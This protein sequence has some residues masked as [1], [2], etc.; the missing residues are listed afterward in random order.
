LIKDNNVH[1][2]AEVLSRI[3]KFSSRWIGNY[4]M[5]LGIRDVYP[6]QDLLEKKEDLVSIW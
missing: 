3:A 1:I 6:R 2:T 4:G 5:S